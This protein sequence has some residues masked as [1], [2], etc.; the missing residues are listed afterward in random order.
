MVSDNSEDFWKVSVDVK[1]RRRKRTGGGGG[2]GYRYGSVV[3][4]GRA[5]SGCWLV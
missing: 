4:F 3:G 2:N 5:K 1:G